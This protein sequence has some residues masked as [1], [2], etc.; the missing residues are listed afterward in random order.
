MDYTYYLTPEEEVVQE[1]R[2]LEAAYCKVNVK[3]A[4]VSRVS[5]EA[6]E[7]LLNH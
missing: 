4:Q 7:A 3:T 2:D 5:K 6:Y 1:S